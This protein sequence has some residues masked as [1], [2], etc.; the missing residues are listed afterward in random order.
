MTRTEAADTYFL[1]TVTVNFIYYSTA[2]H[3]PL[4]FNTQTSVR[5]HLSFLRVHRSCMTS[6]R[7]NAV[8]S[9]QPATPRQPLIHTAQKR[10]QSRGT[11]WTTLKPC[12]LSFD[13][14]SH[15]VRYVSA[16]CPTIISH[17]CSQVAG[18]I[19]LKIQL[20]CLQIYASRPFVI[21]TEFEAIR[22]QRMHIRRFIQL[23]SFKAHTFC[24]IAYP[25]TA[26]LAP[27]C[28]PVQGKPIIRYKF[29]QFDK[30]PFIN[31][32]FLSTESITKNKA[33]TA[34]R[35]SHLGSYNIPIG[36]L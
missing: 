2:P 22:W 20:N 36:T 5:Y 33:R 16:C 19:F 7:R 26:N 23:D 1:R 8:S 31:R 35:F 28:P 29:T 4:Q 3:W 12:P 14:N 17:N 15:A 34:G 10:C 11:L 18:P 24:P 6:S 13:P 25:F 30:L 9:F 27:L 32:L 21:S